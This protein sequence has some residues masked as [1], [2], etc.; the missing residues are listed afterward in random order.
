MEIDID[1]KTEKPVVLLEQRKRKVLSESEWLMAW[2]TY[3]AVYLEKFP[4]EVHRMLT[5]Q[6]NIQK[7]MTKNAN[8]RQF[9]LKF[10]QERAYG[11]IPWHAIRPDLERDAYLSGLNR[12]N[13]RDSNMSHTKYTHNSQVPKGYCFA[14]NT[15]TERC[16]QTQCHYKHACPQ[17]GG[18][19][20]GYRH[21]SDSKQN[22][23]RPTPTQSSTR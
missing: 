23:K 21:T 14:Y 20:P 17:C 19:H 12:Q 1:Q 6:K 3:M 2:N 11:N 4:K 18:S 7:M 5:Y 16:I 15:Q 13:F 22:T 8:W 10:R 9:D